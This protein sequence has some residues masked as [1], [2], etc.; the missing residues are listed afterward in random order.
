MT[1]RITLGIDPGQTG[2]IAIL[3]DGTPSG[4]IDMPVMDR[5]AGGHEINALDLAARLRGVLQRHPGA[6]V[7]AILE[8]VSAMPKQG[9]T[10]GFRFGESFGV[11]KGVLAALGIG[12]V[13]VPPQMWKKHLRLTGCD[14]DA[15]RTLVIQR[16][17]EAAP[18]MTRKKDVGRADAL[19][20]AHWGEITEQVQRAA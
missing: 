12:Y 8:A 9:V 16:F 17:P 5:R 7:V 20:L 2:A 11:V 14:K 4:F 1:N 10:S 6:F 15:A 3:A 18:S 13:L 19:L